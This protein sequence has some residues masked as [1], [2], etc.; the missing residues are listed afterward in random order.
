[1]RIRGLSKKLHLSRWVVVSLAI[2]VALASVGVTYA[3]MKAPKD[4][5]DKPDIPVAVAGCSDP[6]TWVHSNDDGT[7]D[8]EYY[9]GVLTVL[10]PGDDGS[11]GEYDWWGEG[12]TSSSNDPGSFPPP[13][14]PPAPG[15]IS[16]RYN[17]DVAR[18]TAWI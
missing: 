6:F 11:V 17:K 5:P 3:G 7:V 12:D 2:V 13:G 16:P 15:D 9:E 8:T 4:K 18:T 10:D 1:M 14:A